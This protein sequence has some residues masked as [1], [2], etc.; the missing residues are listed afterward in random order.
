MGHIFRS[1]SSREQDWATKATIQA[2]ARLCAGL[3]DTP[4]YRQIGQNDIWIAS[5][6]I[7]LSLPLV[8]RNVRHFYQI[9]GL[10]L[11]VIGN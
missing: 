9:K 2:Y 3:Q 10:Q 11:K 7:A 4:S 8:T 5:V 6:G 1:Q